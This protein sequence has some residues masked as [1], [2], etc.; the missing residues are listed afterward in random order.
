MKFKY[1]IFDVDTI[2]VP[3]LFSNIVQH[4]AV[5]VAG[6]KPVAAGFVDLSGVPPVCSGKS[7][8]LGLGSRGAS[9]ADIIQKGNIEI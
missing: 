6:G 3:V 2:P 9:D 1:I 7:V 4:E 5:T 8:S